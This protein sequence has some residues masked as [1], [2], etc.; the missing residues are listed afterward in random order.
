MP[1]RP[2]QGELPLPVLPG[3]HRI[4]VNWQSDEGAGLRTRAPAVDLHSASSNVSV[5]VRLPTDRWVLYAGGRGVG[6]A[7]LYWGELLVFIALAVLL[8]RSG[9]T[10]LKMHE[11][12][13]LGFGLSTFSW[14]VLLL[15]AAWLFAIR[16]RERLDTSALGDM[17]FKVMQALLIV[18]SVVTVLSVV[19]AIPNG[20]LATPNMR[21]AGAG[22]SAGELTWFNDLSRGALP[23]PWVLSVSLWWYKLAML[24]W[25]LW[26]A[27]ALVRWV[28]LVWRGLSV[29]GFWR[30]RVKDAQAATDAP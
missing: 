26:L 20:L 1:V 15:F 29:G 19:A 24:L 25:A 30:A 4:Q 22:Q 7:I 10:P 9:R 3:A 18:L 17:R 6:P 5:T 11:W 27:F 8:A 28:P 23:T 14:G 16:G 12:L 2:D 21:I 13:L